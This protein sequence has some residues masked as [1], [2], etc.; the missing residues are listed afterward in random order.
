MWYFGTMWYLV[1]FGPCVLWV[2]EDGLHRKMGGAAFLW[3]M[4]TLFL[5]PIALPVYMTKRPLK[6]DEVR[7]GGTAWNVLKGF[8]ILWTILMPVATFSVVAKGARTVELLA[9]LGM[10]WF[11]P[12]TGATMLA[13]LLKKN[14]IVEKG[15]T[16][17]LAEDHGQGGQWVRFRLLRIT[18]VVLVLIVVA[19]LADQLLLRL[20][21]L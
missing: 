13:F 2:L 19:L 3:A 6:E 17:P 4:R 5:G 7:E 11:L 14:S 18:L 16:G 8:A 9:V 10:A 20:L 12:T 1:L 21:Y 15:P